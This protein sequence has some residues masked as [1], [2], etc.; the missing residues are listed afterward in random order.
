MGCGVGVRRLD[1]G[2]CSTLICTA[3]MWPLLMTRAC[4]D[5]GVLMRVSSI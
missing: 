2:G 1:D 5:D 3:N 4:D